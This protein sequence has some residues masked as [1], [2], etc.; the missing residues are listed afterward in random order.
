VISDQL[1]TTDRQLRQMLRSG[2]FD[3]LAARHESIAYARQEASPSDVA[4][5]R[6]GWDEILSQRGV[7]RGARETDAEP[8]GSRR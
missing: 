2:V 6:R 4:S 7:T 3:E 1:T 8:V 5:A